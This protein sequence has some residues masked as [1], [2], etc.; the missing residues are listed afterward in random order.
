MYLTGNPCNA[1]WVLNPSLPGPR[2]PSLYAGLALKF[3]KRKQSNSFP[4]LP[5]CSSLLGTMSK[6]LQVLVI[7]Y[8]IDIR[9]F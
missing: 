4:L 8:K 3:R 9:V 1:C 7:N 2:F 5:T 6:W